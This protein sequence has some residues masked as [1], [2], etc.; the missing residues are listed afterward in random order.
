MLDKLGFISFLFL[1][2]LSLSIRLGD[3]IVII[4]LELGYI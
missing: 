1:L 3:M 4:L 2:E